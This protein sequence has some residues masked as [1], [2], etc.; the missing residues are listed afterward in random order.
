MATQ[1]ISPANLVHCI[2]FIR[3]HRVMLDYDLASLYGVETKMLKRAVRRNI[4][5][6]PNDFMFE[7]TKDEFE[8]LRRQIGTSNNETSISPAHGGT[9]Y[10]PFAFSEQ[11]VAMLS[12]VL[13][14][15]RAIQVNIAIMRTFVKI[16]HM[17]E[18]NQE[19][20]D[21]LN[22]LEE[23]YDTQFKAVFDALRLLLDPLRKPKENEIG[24]RQDK[25]KQER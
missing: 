3:G 7:L 23:K 8:N 4:T 11:G 19:L 12:G 25:S 18:T 21:K 17:I 13:N 1:E 5:R 20:A 6:F 22:K 14:S 2:Y 24:F 15:E 10:L 9:R 16:R